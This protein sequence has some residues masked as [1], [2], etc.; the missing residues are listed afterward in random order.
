MTI[1]KGVSLFCS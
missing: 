1:L